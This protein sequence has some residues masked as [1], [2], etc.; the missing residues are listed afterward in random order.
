MQDT[1]D[2]S[3]IVSLIMQ[4]PSLIEQISAL[5]KQKAVP[6]PVAEEEQSPQKEELPATEASAVPIMRSHRHELL[7]AMKPYL[8]ENRRTAIDSMASILDVID[9]MMKKG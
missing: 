4:N 3:T 7:N 1:Q 5:A 8:S 2:L 9:V 6:E